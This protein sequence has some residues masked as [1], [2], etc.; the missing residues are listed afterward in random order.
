MLPSTW[1]RLSFPLHWQGAR[2]QVT[3][4]RDKLEVERVPSEAEASAGSKLQDMNIVIH[5]RP[6]SLTD[7]LIID[8]KEGIP[9][10]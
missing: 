5:G 6:C 2:L 10:E 7:H 3:V 9:V 4:S 1:D 8:L